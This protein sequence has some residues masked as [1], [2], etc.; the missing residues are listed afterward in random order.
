MSV[1]FKSCPFMCSHR[2]LLLH[3]ILDIL[4]QNTLLFYSK[5]FTSSVLAHSRALRNFWSFSLFGEYLGDARLTGFSFR[6]CSNHTYMDPQNTSSPETVWKLH[7]DLTMQRQI[8]RKDQLDSQW[9][10]LWRILC[11]N[12]DFGLR[13]CL[14]IIWSR[15]INY[16]LIVL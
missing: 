12:P 6:Q 14:W 5:S 15:L 3:S 13:W 4:P 10:F 2:D 7:A 1:S 16:R 11:K 9:A 8:A